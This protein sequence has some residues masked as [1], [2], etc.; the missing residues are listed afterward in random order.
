M[1]RWLGTAMVAVLLATAVG[2]DVISTG[3]TVRLI[4]NASYAV[5]ATVLYHENQLIPEALL[6]EVG[7]ELQYTIPDGGTVSFSQDC[8]DLQAIQV[9]GDLQGIFGLGGSKTSRV[10]RDGDDFG[11]NDAITFTFTSDA[12]G[13]SLNISFSN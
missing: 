12:L 2:C 8:D 7:T 3:T 11:C 9:A 10:Y 5:K 6:K 1:K 4:N 13:T